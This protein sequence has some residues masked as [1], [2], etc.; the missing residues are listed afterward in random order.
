M[1]AKDAYI[2]DKK[3][4]DEIVRHYSRQ[5]RLVVW[6]LFVAL[7]VS[8]FVNFMQGAYNQTVKTT[9]VAEQSSSIYGNV[10][11]SIN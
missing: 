8:M 11:T 6:V 4:E 2:R 3:F 7:L 9:A 1:T 5:N 10:S